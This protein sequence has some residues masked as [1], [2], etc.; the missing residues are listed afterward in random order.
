MHDMIL[1]WMAMIVI[2]CVVK[3]WV[4]DCW[5]MIKLRVW[6]VY[7]N[8]MGILSITGDLLVYGRFCQNFNKI[9]IELSLYKKIHQKN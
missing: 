3:W 2:T 1:K 9:L 5:T 7:Q 6:W 4:Q 8:V